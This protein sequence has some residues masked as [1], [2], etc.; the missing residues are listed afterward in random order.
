[1]DI[2]P[3]T[4]HINFGVTES[5]LKKSILKS[6]AISKNREIAEQ[7]RLLSDSQR[8]I[9]NF[10]L[11]ASFLLSYLILEQELY[12]RWDDKIR[13]FNL[14]GVRMSQL[15][16]H[17]KMWQTSRVIEMANLFGVIDNTEYN[18]LNQFRLVRNNLAHHGTDVTENDAHRCFNLAE[19]LILKKVNKINIP[20]VKKVTW[21]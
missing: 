21:H 3:C 5:T 15:L 14:N 10:E 13:S 17:N 19:K 1:M 9:D 6:I 4:T 2:D 20:D 7:F 8:H 16:D 12:R 18:R 11:S